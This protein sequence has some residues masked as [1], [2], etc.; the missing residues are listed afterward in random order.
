MGERSIRFGITDGS[1]RRAATWKCWTLTGVGKSDVYLSARELGYA[2]KASLHQSG[3]WQ[4]AFSPQFVE[5][6][7]NAF[8]DKPNGRFI[9]QWPRPQQ[10]APGVTLAFR[11]VTPHSAVNIPF[12]I[13]LYK[14]IVWIPA[15]PDNR[16]V[17]IDII[18][19]APDTLVSGWPCKNSMNTQLIDSMS[20]S[21]GEKVWVVHWVTDMPNLG[22]LHGT[23][24]YFKDK[25]K[26]DL[27]GAGLHILVFGDEKDG[28]RVI[29][30]CPAEKCD[31]SN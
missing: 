26:D 21:S 7:P 11:I 2:L 15:P 22:T 18:F 3:N 28:S 25:N 20:L 24:R 30:D 6:N 9:E 19:T 29:Y 27:I 12:D 8:S 23:P 4:V 5:E 1:G 10:I 13:S 14:S 16:A 31:S 17:E